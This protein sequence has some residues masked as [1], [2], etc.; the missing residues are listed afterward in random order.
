MKT[1]IEDIE[2]CGVTL[3]YQQRPEITFDSD[4]RKHEENKEQTQQQC[5]YI[6]KKYH[7]GFAKAIDHTG[8]SGT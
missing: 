3:A 7:A 4:G 1:K 5:G 2:Q 8:E 6:G